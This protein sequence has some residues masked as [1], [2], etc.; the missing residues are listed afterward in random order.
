MPSVNIKEIDKTT[1]NDVTYYDYTILI[2]GMLGA[3]Q[4]SGGMAVGDEE[5]FSD[6]ATFKERVGSDA[7]DVSYTMAYKLLGL[8]IRVLYV[9]IEGE[10]S[11]TDAFYK[12][13]Q[14]K[15]IYDLRFITSGSYASAT[16]AHSVILC[17]AERGD[18][19]AVIDVPNA[20]DGSAA[21]I[22]T[23]TAS[24]GAVSVT[25]ADG[26]VEDGMKYASIFAPG[27]TLGDTTHMPASFD[28]LSCFA[29]FIASYPAWFAMAGSIRGV[30]PETVAAVDTEFGDADNS[31]L[32]AREVNTTNGI[33]ADHRACNTISKIRPYGYVLWGNRTMYPLKTGL[34]ASS[35]L[36]IRQLCCTLKKVMYRA[37][38]KYTFEPNSDVLWTNFV[39]AITPTLEDMKSG[40]G[41]KGYKII[42][43]TT[44]KKATLKAR[45]RIIPI[46]AVEDFDLTVELTDS[47]ETGEEEA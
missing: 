24:I 27:I 21:D 28:Y 9:A 8:G 42:K 41:I 33:T 32:Q 26:T 36:N 15:G 37:A 5:E 22:D 25:R 30:C 12:K 43:E 29:S 6:Q 16:I 39:N 23:Y 2:P 45:V 18:A 47:I 31:I 3:T 20:S 38:R 34:V 17:A 10:D 1:A 13:Y 40:Q 44:G 11:L 46:E 4:E 7:Q 35:F 14:D 19:T